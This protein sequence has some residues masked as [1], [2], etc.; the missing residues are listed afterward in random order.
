MAKM[1]SKPVKSVMK[2]QRDPGGFNRHG[3]KHTTQLGN[4]ILKAPEAPKLPAKGL[5]PSKDRTR[6]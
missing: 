6:P 1:Y 4:E 3:A 2:K 5:T